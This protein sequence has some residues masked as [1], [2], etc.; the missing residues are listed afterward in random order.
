ML[1]KKQNYIENEVITVRNLI[2]RVIEKVAELEELDGLRK[3][4]LVNKVIKEANIKK[5]LNKQISKDKPASKLNH[6]P[7]GHISKYI[8]YLKENKLAYPKMNKLET[9]ILE[10]I[11]DFKHLEVAMLRSPSRERAY[12]DA[13]I[14]CYYIFREIL[15]YIYAKVGLI[16]LR[17]HSTIIHGLETHESLMSTDYKYRNDFYFI[18]DKLVEE[19][20]ED[21]HS[22]DAAMLK[23]KYGKKQRSV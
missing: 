8:K 19:F 1:N 22:Y 15:G 3:E 17:D 20:P 14:M 12:V 23:N 6:S 2:G 16:F 10:L 5:Y 13:R 11:S 7:R 18:M 9:R 21:F 4:Y